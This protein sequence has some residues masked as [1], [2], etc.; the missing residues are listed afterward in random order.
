MNKLIPALLLANLYFASPVQ[1]ENVPSVHYKSD[2][3][4]TKTLR[5]TCNTL[6]IDTFREGYLFPV[7]ADDINTTDGN[8]GAMLELF[9]DKIYSSHLKSVGVS[10]D[11]LRRQ[12]LE[13]NPDFLGRTFR[14]GDVL[15]F[16]RALVEKSMDSNL[17]C[18][19][20]QGN[21]GVNSYTR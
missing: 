7:T 9:V 20:I 6:T 1:A 11:Y 4:S 10:S 12:I 18:A 14:R 19:L 17:W 16:E 8:A 2:H 5:G 15:Y 21:S 3:L 13:L